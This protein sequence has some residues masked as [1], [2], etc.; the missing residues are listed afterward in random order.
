MRGA[1]EAVQPWGT[2]E[3]F[4]SAIGFCTLIIFG[5]GL[6]TKHPCAVEAHLYS[7]VWQGP[8]LFPSSLSSPLP[9]GQG[10]KRSRSPR[11]SKPSDAVADLVHEFIDMVVAGEVV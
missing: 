11:R 1:A 6:C 8:E 2:R 4:C 5:K 3:K 10:S 7:N 9:S